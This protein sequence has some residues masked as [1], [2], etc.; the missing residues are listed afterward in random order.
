MSRRAELMD[1]TRQRIVDATVELHGSIG[2]AAT[3]IAAIA[4]LAGV[5]RLTVYRHFPDEATLIGACSAHWL[6]QQQRPDPAAW[7]QIADPADRLRAGL[8]DLYRFYRAG[9]G[10]LAN[11]YRD[12]AVL[13][14]AQR[15]ALRDRDARHREVLAAPFPG[16]PD[17]RPRLLAVISHAASF[18]TWY[19][20]CSEHGLSDSD[21]VDVMAGAV[22]SVLR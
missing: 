2:L 6:A 21:A 11:V 12:F 15:Q 9:A 3:T 22:M 8:A 20:L 17:Q 5:T 16:D 19:S 4:D 18:M 1:Q 7:A 10:M 13:P 14:E